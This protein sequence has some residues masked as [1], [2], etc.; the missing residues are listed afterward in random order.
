VGEGNGVTELISACAFDVIANGVGHYSFAKALTIELR[1]LSKK[2]S[3]PVSE[4][5]T[6]IYCRA[7]HHLA[8]GIANERYPAPIHLQLTRDDQFARGLHLSIQ[9]RPV[10]Q[11]GGGALHSS[12]LGDVDKQQAETQ[13]TNLQCLTT[14]RADEVYSSPVALC[15]AELAGMAMLRPAC[16]SPIISN[17]NSNSSEYT[18]NTLPP[19]N[20]PRLLL[21][22]RLEENIQAED[23]ST[24]FFSEWLRIIPTAVKEVKV[25]AGFKC[26]S[27][28]VLMSLPLSLWPYLPQHPAIFLLGLIKSSNLLTAKHQNPN[29]LGNEVC[30]SEG[31]KGK[32][33]RVP[34]SEDTPGGVSG[35]E[36]ESGDSL[37]IESQAMGIDQSIDE[38]GCSQFY[39]SM[40]LTLKESLAEAKPFRQ[41]LKEP[42]D[43]KEMLF[44][45]S[46]GRMSSDSSIARVKAWNDAFFIRHDPADKDNVAADEEKKKK[47]YTNDSLR[48]IMRASGVKEELDY[49][50]DASPSFQVLK[51]GIGEAGTRRASWIDDRNSP[52][53]SGKGNIR[54]SD[55]P[56]TATDLLGYLSQRV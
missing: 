51:A 29:T 3:F 1:L 15:P 9:D 27:T 16:A 5:Y 50:C 46:V 23:L 40:I 32:R 28:L 19:E 37:F 39:G 6:H 17:N 22:I 14:L 2:I 8:Q 26:D 24:E 13:T 4:L 21:A 43:G 36:D 48:G 35:G 53:L 33:E 56:L 11:D 31:A 25:E 47:E 49:L 44:H 34:V 7:Q 45:K 10:T 20:T 54:R 30:S 41:P 38:T 18:I 12:D 55:N 42:S 52:D